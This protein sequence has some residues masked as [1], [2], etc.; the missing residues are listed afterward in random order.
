MLRVVL[1][2]RYPLELTARFRQYTFE[3]ASG[4]ARSGAK[5]PCQTAG[6]VRHPPQNVEGAYCD[7]WRTFLRSRST[8]AATAR[9]GGG[10]ALPHVGFGE[11]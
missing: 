11:P 1:E 7:P 2:V 4:H 9:R 5:A 10:A 6:C 8:W 3:P